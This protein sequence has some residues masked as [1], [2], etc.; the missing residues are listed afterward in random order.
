MARGANFKLS[1]RCIVL[2]WLVLT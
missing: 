1:N 2:L